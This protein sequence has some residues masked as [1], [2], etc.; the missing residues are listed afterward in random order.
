MTYD[1]AIITTT[2][3]KLFDSCL[4]SVRKILDTTPLKVAYV[5]VDNDS[6]TIDVH[7][8]VKA[9]IP[10]AE[11]ILRAKNHGM[12]R[13]CNLA[14][15]NVEAN[16]YFFLNPDTDIPDIRIFHEL[17]QFLETHP[18]AGIVAPRLVYPNGELQKT[19]CRFHRWYTPIAER[20]ELIP[21]GRRERHHHW[22]LMDEYSHDH[23]RMVDWVQGSA[24]MISAKLFH[25][26]GGFDE[27][28]HL[29]LEDMDLCRECW[30]RGR[31]VYYLPE[32]SMMHAYGK[33]SKDDRGIVRSILKNPAT[34]YHIE[35]WLKYQW[36]WAKKKWQG[37]VL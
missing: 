28:Y 22:F 36:K 9:L 32:L 27:R 20:T 19:C 13:S 18:Q 23:R 4:A 14:A 34:R 25:E 29:Y 21:S 24:F 12:G 8:K 6:H 31:P 2:Y 5:V 17:H 15:Q 30:N 7:G 35:S 26:I 10:E 37:Y 33:A 3:N 1:I 11:V 16:Y